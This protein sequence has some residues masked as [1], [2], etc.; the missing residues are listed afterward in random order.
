MR[1]IA[2]IIGLILITVPCLFGQE[3]PVQRPTGDLVSMK[4]DLKMETA[5]GI[6]ERY[7]QRYEGKIFVYLGTYAGPIGID[8]DRLQW[9]A[10]LRSI[11]KVHGLEY[12][13]TEKAYIIDL[14]K[15]EQGVPLAVQERQQQEKVES[16]AARD[17]VMIE[18]TFFE[19]DRSALD[20]VGIDWTTIGDGKVKF[21]VDFMAGSRVTQSIMDATYED[22]YD[23]GS[24]TIDLNVLFRIFESLDRGH[25]ISRPQ[26][27]VTSGEE[28]TIHDGEKFSIKT[29]D[30]AGN[31]TDTF[32]DTGTIVKVKPEVKTDAEGNKYIRLEVD[33]QRSSGEPSSV[34]YTI[35]ISETNTVKTLYDGEE[36]VIS[37]LTVKERQEIRAGIPILKDL[38]WWVFGLRYVTGYNMTSVNTK[39]LLII[40]RATI[41]DPL[42]ERVVRRP[43]LRRDIQTIRSRIPELEEKLVPIEDQSQE[44]PAEPME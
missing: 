37:G 41:L 42:D 36:A 44:E 5:L 32:F 8:I 23:T 20:E 18:L 16:L 30:E 27:V 43:E 38:P 34:S 28:G 33:A 9:Q 26:V 31:T 2:V 1:R 3:E 6:L 7:L 11:L 39:E 14:V 29:K 13:E 25:V 21:N 15:D 40:L 19:A 35:K 4:A 22:T 17:E 10:A 12:R 24:G